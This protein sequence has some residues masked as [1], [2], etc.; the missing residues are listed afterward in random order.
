MF[1][2]V[3]VLES[4]LDRGVRPVARF[5]HLRLGLSPNQVSWGAL[6]VSLAA[7]GAIVAGRIHLG[8]ALTF[9]G[10]LVDAWDGCIARE[11]GLSSPA[12]ARLDTLIDR[13]SEGAIFAGAAV[14]GLAPVKIIALA[15]VAILL[16]S[17]VAVRSRFDPGVKRVALYFGLWFPFPALFTVIFAVNLAGYV[18]ALLV[19]D[20]QFQKRMDRLGGDLDTIASRAV[21][22]EQLEEL[23]NR[24]PETAR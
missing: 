24:S 10:Q 6:I 2:S 13:L 19:C 17:S 15:F 8:L 20:I 18:V 7:A 23:A 14:A 22:E 9:V 3:P 1:E 5:L 16:V 4:A 11:F 21:R 12:G